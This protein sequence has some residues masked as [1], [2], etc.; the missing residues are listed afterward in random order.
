MPAPEQ[1][2]AETSEQASGSLRTCVVTREEGP[3]ETMIRFVLD[4]A[5]NVTPDLRRKLPGRGVWTRTSAKV[6][7][8]AVRRRAFERGFKT[9]ATAP[10][11]LVALVD[12]LMETDCLQALAMAN[13]AGLVV[14]GFA[15]VE[16]EIASGAVAALFHAV[17]GGADGKRKL[18]QA[19]RR[20]F[21]DAPP[22]E[23]ETFDS[24]QL[25]LAL[26]RTNV[27]HAALRTGPASTGLVARCAKLQE[28]RADGPGPAAAKS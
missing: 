6:V 15:K 14:T 25:D 5:G 24:R 22:G 16:A 3:P 18:G 7:A 2:P 1:E 12:R 19:L 20:R 8:E 28:F 17:D 26:G 9:K 21:G 4:P 27:I 23:I 11:G 10:D 13:K